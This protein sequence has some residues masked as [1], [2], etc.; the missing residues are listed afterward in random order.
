MAYAYRTTDI[1][2]GT[3]IR[4]QIIDAKSN[5][6]LA[7][8]PD[9]SSEEMKHSTLAFTVPAGASLLRLRLVY[10]RA[11]GTP[12]ISGMLVILST[13]IQTHP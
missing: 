13:E 4:W 6:I 2:E 9:L 1:P 8:S 3:G 11:L 12:R 7:D 5:T 10:R